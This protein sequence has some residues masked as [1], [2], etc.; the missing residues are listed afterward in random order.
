MTQ[1]LKDVG[2]YGVIGG[3]NQEELEPE[4]RELNKDNA[5]NKAIRQYLLSGTLS[6]GTSAIKNTPNGGKR[7]IVSNKQRAALKR[8]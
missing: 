5:W 2:G 4:K 3:H 1:K 7:L 8:S 6:G